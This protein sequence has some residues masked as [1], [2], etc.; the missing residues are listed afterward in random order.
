MVLRPART[1]SP[2]AYRL[3]PFVRAHAELVASWAVD[4][5]EAFWLAPKT[6][7][8]LTAALVRGWARP[9][10]EQLQLVAEPDLM[11]VAYGEL[12]V[13]NRERAEY[14]LGHLIVAPD[15]RGCGIGKAL[16]RALLDRARRHYAARS[17]SLVVFPE[18]AVAR[19]CYAAVGFRAAGFETHDLRPSRRGVRLLRMSIEFLA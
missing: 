13:L 3:Q 6:P 11:P 16:T 14:W 15:Q 17:V 8:P 19:S 10:V 5:Q 7:A 4:E 9:G 2:R 1:E 18:N 12:N